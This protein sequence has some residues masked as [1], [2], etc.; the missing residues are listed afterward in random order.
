MGLEVPWTLLN[1]MICGLELGVTLLAGRPSAGKTTMEDCISTHLAS[2][3]IPVGRVT[4]DG[5]REEL[6]AR[7]LS[8]KAGVSMYKLKG[9]FVKEGSDQDLQVDESAE[10]LGAYPMYI[11]ET[12]RD[13]KDIISQARYWVAKHDIKLLTLDYIQQVNASE[14]GR[15]QWDTTGKVTHCS[16]AM[17]ALSLEL[18]IPVLVLCQL[19]RSV[20][21]EGRTP[22]LSDLRD[23]GGL[24][25]D[26]HKV[27]FL[28]PDVSTMKEMEERDEKRSWKKR[29]PVWVDVM[30]QKDGE[31][32]RLPYILRG[33][34]YEFEEGPAG[35]GFEEMMTGGLL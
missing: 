21:K 23:S 3:G 24:E 28:Y 19:S 15:S 1:E 7:A 34:Y 35:V 18:K 31:T 12:A 9:G 4:L 2:L 22:Q 8:R 32:G 13:I 29:K 10:I 26:A 20:E 27:I 5:S 30:K 33:P 14:M 11:T 25:Q 17:K 6:M 16:S